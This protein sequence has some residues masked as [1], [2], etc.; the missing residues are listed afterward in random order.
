M[1]INRKY[2]RLI[3]LLISVLVFTCIIS[4]GMVVSI[5]GIHENFITIWL[6]SWLSAYCIAFPTI[7]FLSEPIAKLVAKIITFED[8]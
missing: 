5:V 8:K 3:T 1:T 6:R 7:W 4:F 2:Q